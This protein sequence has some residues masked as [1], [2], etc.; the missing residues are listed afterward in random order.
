MVTRCQVCECVHRLPACEL[1]VNRWACPCY[2]CSL[3]VSR[4][5]DTKNSHSCR[6][7]RFV[8]MSIVHTYIRVG[9]V[10]SRGQSRLEYVESRKCGITVVESID[11]FE[12]ACGAI[13]RSIFILYTWWLYSGRVSRV[14]TYIEAI[15]S[16]SILQKLFVYIISPQPLAANLQRHEKEKR[17]SSLFSMAYCVCTRRACLARHRR[18]GSTEGRQQMAPCDLWPG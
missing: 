17:D 11:R 13:I 18:R 6:M 3:I 12:S 10:G 16:G 15:L 7:E 9:P 5:L 14:S 8:M 4:R 2:L 1:F